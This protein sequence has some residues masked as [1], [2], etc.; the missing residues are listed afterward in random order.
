MTVIC[1]YVPNDG[2]EYPH[3]GCSGVLE[4]VSSRDSIF[5]LLEQL[6]THMGIDSVTWRCV[7]E[8][9]GLTDLNA[10]EVL[11]LDLLSTA[12]PYSSISVFISRHGIRSL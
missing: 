5:L 11:L 7:I 6:N 2:S 3:L 9:N 12:C 4:S 10:S 1:A 8:T